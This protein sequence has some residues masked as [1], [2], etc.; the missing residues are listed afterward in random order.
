MDINGE[1]TTSTSNLVAL[2]LTRLTSLTAADTVDDDVT[3]DVDDVTWNADDHGGFDDVGDKK[4]FNLSC[5][6]VLPSVACCTEERLSAHHQHVTQPANS[7][8][9]SDSYHDCQHLSQRQLKL[10]VYPL[11][12]C[13]LTLNFFF[14]ILIRILQCDN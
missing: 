6:S 5:D 9:D 3:R 14:E 7:S 4:C 1:L 8:L 10:F 2:R 11:Q 12:M 13:S